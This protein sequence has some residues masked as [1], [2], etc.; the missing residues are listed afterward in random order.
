MKVLVTG[1]S[2]FIGSHL[3][4]LLAE[5]RFEIVAASRRKR[6]SSQAIEWRN[7]PEL[8]QDADWSVA[9]QGVDAVVHLAGRAQIGAESSAEEN[10]CLRINT[11]GTRKLAQQAVRSGVG[12]FIFVSSC[13]AVAAESDLP[14]NEKTAPR[15]SSPYGR[16]KLAAEEDVREEMK[17]T[18]CGWT[19]LRPPPVYGPGQQSNFSRLLSL[20]Q[21]GIPLPLASVRNR[22]SFIYVKNLTDAIVACLGNSVSNG[23][24]YYP[25]D[26]ED[27]STPELLRAIARADQSGRCSVP[28]DSIPN[29]ATSHVST[30][31]PHSLRLFPFPESML[32]VMGRLPGLGPL[33]KLTGSLYVDSG[34]IRHDL[35]WTPPFTLSDGLME[36]IREDI[37]N[38]A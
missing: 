9:L 12:H 36:T 1:A 33:R 28:S 3:L 24:T 30:A 21:R 38:S 4:P 23:K 15:P 29:K 5:S 17:G 32:N 20:V 18:K 16:S 25:S 11:E 22:R 34:L 6:A 27:I 8:G 37:R 31:T 26:G 14:L 13:Q 19:I 2:G 10:A 35:R 7:S